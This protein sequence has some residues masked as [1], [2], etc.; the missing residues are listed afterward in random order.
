MLAQMLGADLSIGAISQAY[1]KVAAALAAP[2]R[3]A[4]DSLRTAP[5]VHM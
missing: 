4:P 2:M 5:V 1:A 3:E